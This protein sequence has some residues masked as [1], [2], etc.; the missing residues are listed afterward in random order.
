[1][2]LWSGTVEKMITM[3][4][5]KPEI[6]RLVLDGIPRN[7]NQ[8]RFL[9]EHVEVQRVFHLNCPDMEKMVER[10]RRRALKDNRLDDASDEVIRKRL[11]TYELETKPVLEHYGPHLISNIDSTQYPFQVLRDILL[12]ITA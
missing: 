1:M 6:D 2:E 3:G 7:V 12:Y 11:E 8:A 9:D 4:R 10:M 5:F